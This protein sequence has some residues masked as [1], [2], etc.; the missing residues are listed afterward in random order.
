MKTNVVVLPRSPPQPFIALSLSLYINAVYV[1]DP[2]RSRKQC[3]YW[4]GGWEVVLIGAGVQ[5]GGTEARRG[6]GSIPQ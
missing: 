6:V 4:K 3:V 1:L 5:V 2:Q